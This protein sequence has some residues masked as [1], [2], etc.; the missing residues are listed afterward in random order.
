MN[1]TP[2]ART[3]SGKIKRTERVEVRATADE[4]ASVKTLMQRRGKTSE[5]DAIFTAVRE[6]IHRDS[7]DGLIDDLRLMM[8][9]AK[10]DN[11]RIKADTG[12]ASEYLD[13]VEVT[14]GKVLTMLETIRNPH[15]K[16]PA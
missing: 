14:V 15:L 16:L 11:Y 7:V 10:V 6:A 9:T 13:G 8:N 3:R 4:K 1:E 5:A 12:R 2:R